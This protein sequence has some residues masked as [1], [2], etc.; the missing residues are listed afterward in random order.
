MSLSIRI[1]IL[2]I[3]TCFGA[4]A[5]FA[6]LETEAKRLQVGQTTK[7]KIGFGHE[8]GNSESAINLDGLELFAIS[9]SGKKVALNPVAADKWVVADFTA[10]ETGVYRFVMTQDRGVMS[11]TTKGFKP[12]GRDVYPDAKKSMKMWR[13]AVTY[14]SAGGDQGHAASLGLPFEVMAQREGSKVLLTV[15]QG[16][17]P[18]PN[19]EISLNVPGQEE[20]NKI[21]VSNQMGNFEYKV[22]G[23]GPN[24]FLVTT[25]SP[26]PPGANYDTENLTSVLVI[27]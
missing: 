3:T 18:F 8:V 5:H 4:A 26:A 16:G 17:R 27:Q 2:A 11:Q 25:A 1:S 13:S 20:A 10:T 7:V 22:P 24:L 6:W 14:V 9:P 15:L 19:A 12:G 23:P 21:G